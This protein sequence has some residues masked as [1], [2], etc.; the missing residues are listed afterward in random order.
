M[1]I[2]IEDFNTNTFS[3]VVLNNLVK[4]G[5]GTLSKTDLEALLYFALIQSNQDLKKANAFEKADI[6]RITDSKLLSLRKRSGV[7]LE[8]NRES[9]Q[10]IF[11][12]FLI[13]SIQFY[14]QFPNESDIRIVIDDEMD[15]RSIQKT[16][17]RLNNHNISGISV[18]I[19]TNGR[20][21]I[22]KQSYLNSVLTL[23]APELNDPQINQLLSAKKYVE[24]RD[25]L[26]KYSSTA[27]KSFIE[28]L[29]QSFYSFV[30]KSF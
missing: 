1:K 15:K 6:L 12:T 30:F 9:D 23:I 21:L 4:F 14:L 19:S 8:E 22:I 28:T 24:F 11:Q 13:R 20:S 3:S 7:W 26:T 2:K 16:L 29:S 10:E 27:L 17:E 5:F 25:A 18:D